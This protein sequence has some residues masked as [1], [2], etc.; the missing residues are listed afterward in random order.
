MACYQVVHRLPLLNPVEVLNWEFM[1]SSIPKSNL[2][3]FSP[4]P[5][6]YAVRLGSVGWACA[7]GVVLP[8][9]CGT[10]TA[11]PSESTLSLCV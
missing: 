4:F 2:C 10:R 7:G 9:V 5:S 1:K 3:V 8:S 6:W 11:E